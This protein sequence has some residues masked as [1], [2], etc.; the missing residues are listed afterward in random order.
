MAD[1]DFGKKCT[2]SGTT[3]KRAGRYYRNGK[4]FRNKAAFKAHM[5]KLLEEQ[6]EKEGKEAA[7]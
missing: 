2:F 5:K 4:Y 3:I 1:E 6:K 7:S